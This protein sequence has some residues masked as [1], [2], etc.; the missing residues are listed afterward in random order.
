MRKKQNRNFSWMKWTK[1][2]Q[3]G[4]NISFNIV[5]Y[6]GIWFIYVGWYT[7]LLSLTTFNRILSNSAKVSVHSCS[8]YVQNNCWVGLRVK[9]GPFEHQIP[10]SFILFTIARTRW[11][12]FLPNFVKTL[13][14][15]FRLKKNY[16]YQYFKLISI[17]YNTI[18]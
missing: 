11:P 5:Y 12:K 8:K 7:W 18:L 6:H 9:I 2:N 16:F 17:L 15:T 1:L 4:L 14:K 10:L 3:M 13:N